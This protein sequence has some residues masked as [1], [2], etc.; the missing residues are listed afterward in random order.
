VENFPNNIGR[1]SFYA[2]MCKLIKQNLY[3]TGK[4]NNI[5]SNLTHLWGILFTKIIAGHTKTTMGGML[6]SNIAPACTKTLQ[7]KQY[8]ILPN[9]EGGIGNA[10]L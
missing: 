2:A 9:T 1:A 5:L 3:Q 4:L 6:S 10:L 8:H 7:F